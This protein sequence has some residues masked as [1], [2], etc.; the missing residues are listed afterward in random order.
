M[1]VYTIAHLKFKDIVAYRRYQQAFSAVFDRFNAKLLA[2]DESP[3]VVEGEWSGDKV[4]MLAFSD[5]AEARRF[6]ED[7]EYQAIAV[8]RYAGADAIVLQVKGWAMKA[9]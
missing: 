2:A 9:G 1:T 7:P 3:K 5:E 4:V 6:H 8:D